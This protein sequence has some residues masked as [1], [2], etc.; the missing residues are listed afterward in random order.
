[1]RVTIYKRNSNSKIISIAAFLRLTAKFSK[2]FFPL[3]SSARS[4]LFHK[5]WNQIKNNGVRFQL[6]C[7]PSRETL[8]PLR[9]ISSSS[10]SEYSPCASIEPADRLICGWVDITENDCKQVGCC[11]Q[12]GDCFKTDGHSNYCKYQLICCSQ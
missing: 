4:R 1:M 9:H 11:Y 12:S 5:P 7:A 2:E 8:I 3:R 6:S 10:L